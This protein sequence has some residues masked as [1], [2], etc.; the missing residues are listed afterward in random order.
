[1]KERTVSL[2]KIAKITAAVVIFNQI[3]VRKLWQIGFVIPQK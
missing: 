2:G 3:G 1:M